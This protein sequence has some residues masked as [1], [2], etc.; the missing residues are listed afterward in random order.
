MPGKRL[1]G[2]GGYR[3]THYDLEL[4]YRPGPARLAGRAV[5][6]AE[7]QTRLEG[8]ALDLGPFRVDRVIVDGRP[9][10]YTHRA[11]KL[12]IRPARAVPAGAP[13]T[14][15]V[16]YAGTPRPVRSHWGEI[17]WDHLSDGALVASQPV[18]APSWFPCN[19]TLAD[20][21]GYRISVRV[22]SPYTVLANGILASRRAGAGATTWV[23]EQAE[24]MC[25]YLATVQIGRY[26]LVELA[27]APVLQ[28][29]AVPPRLV[30][31][32]IH[33]FGRQP[34]MLSAFADLFGEYP[35]TG[36]AVVVTGEDL[37]VP[38]EAQGLS[39][40]GANHV[41]GARGAEHL[42]AHELAHQWFGNSLTVADWRHIWLHEGFA[43]YAEWLWSEISGGEPAGRLAERSW[44]ALSAQPRDLVLANPGLP[45]TFD[46]R[47]YQRGALTL[48]ALRSTMGDAPFFG[49]LRDWT[50]IHRHGSVTT[51]QFTQLAQRHTPRPLDTLFADWL[52][53][54]RLPELPRG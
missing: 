49:L 41:D 19:D 21:A 31:A 51:T 10:H 29:A 6:S 43:Q 39:T 14:V 15:E 2:N 13:F 35:F 8:F 23:Y 46:D 20:K 5:I 44:T 45:R 16:R 9:A 54:V 34:E 4:D 24:P 48:H 26:D 28:V 38:V 36:Y 17:G 25:T 12:R 33:D 37:D 47:V 50:E 27:G 1:P 52:Y 22:A 40:F 3:V 53:G 18:G 7:S 42:V 11:G 30:T 32:A